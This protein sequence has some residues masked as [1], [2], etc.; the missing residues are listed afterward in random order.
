MIFSSCTLQTHFPGFVVV[1][2]ILLFNRSLASGAAFPI[3]E[4]GGWTD[5]DDEEGFRLKNE[6]KLND[7]F[8]IGLGGSTEGDTLFGSI[9]VVVVAFSLIECDEVAVDPTAC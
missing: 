4:S 7:L 6:G 2:A 3:D 8:V 9:V 1:F 5:D